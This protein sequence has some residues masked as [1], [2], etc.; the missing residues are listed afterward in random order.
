MP[1]LTIWPARELLAAWGAPTNLRALRD[2]HPGGLA[3]CV[4]A[5]PQLTV[6]ASELWRLARE[7]RR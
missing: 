7:P 3:V 5:T 4:V 6:A 2:A 1:T